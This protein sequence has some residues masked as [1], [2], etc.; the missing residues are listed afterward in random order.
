MSSN[1]MEKSLD[2]EIANRMKKEAAEFGMTLSE[3]MAFYLLHEV[4][5]L[6]ARVGAIQRQLD[7]MQ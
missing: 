3:Y 6:T 2:M 5:E 4:R 1:S 7:D